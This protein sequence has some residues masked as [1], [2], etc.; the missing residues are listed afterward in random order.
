MTVQ[1][2]LVAGL[3]SA[4]A[5]AVM[6]LPA[7]ASANVCTTECGGGP[8]SAGLTTA[9]GAVSATDSTQVAEGIIVDRLALNHNETVLS[10]A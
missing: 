9:L 4:S 10:L 8:G 2:K 7:S 3:V 1:G 5:A 6:W